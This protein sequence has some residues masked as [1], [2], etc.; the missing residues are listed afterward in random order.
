LEANGMKVEDAGPEF[1][2]ELEA[3]G[4]KM[5]ADWLSEVGADGQAILDAYNAN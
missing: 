2:A 5:K 3:I 4:A 1:L